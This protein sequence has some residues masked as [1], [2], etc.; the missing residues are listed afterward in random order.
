[1]HTTLSH[2]SDEELLR[3][4]S[5]SRHRSP[6]IAELCDRLEAALDANIVM[7]NTF[8]HSEKKVQCPVCLASL[9]VTQ[10]EDLIFDLKMQ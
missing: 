7:E 1:M 4:L 10:N 8:E 3:H 2:L 5:D 9:E 6:I